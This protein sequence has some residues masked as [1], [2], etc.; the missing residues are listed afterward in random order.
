M[1]DGRNSLVRLVVSDNGPGVPAADRD[2]LF[3]PYYSTKGRGS[4][5]RCDGRH[6]FGW[7][8]KAKLQG[9]LIDGRYHGIAVGCYL[10]GG[11]SGPRENVRMVLEDDGS[12]SL[13][14]GS[15]SV[16]QGVETVFAQIA[17]DALEMPME[18]I[19]RVQHGSTT[20]VKQGYGSYSSRSIVM[21]GSAIVQAAA[22]LRMRSAPPRPGACN[23][24]R[25]RLRSTATMPSGRTA[26]ALRSPRS[27]PT[28][29]ARTAPIRA[30]SALIPMVRMPPTLRSIRAP[31][32]S[33]SSTTWRSRTS[34][35]SSIR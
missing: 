23:A 20:Y 27:P 32:T 28:V 24:T 1:H 11:G 16:G 4:G 33:R 19:N 17:A 10:E 2:K 29:L 21:G 25:A 14:V 34:A 31:A 35:G 22:N 8:E 7:A 26:P 9:A 18:R 5:L 15:S 30:T 12:V 13:Y 6:D 3:M